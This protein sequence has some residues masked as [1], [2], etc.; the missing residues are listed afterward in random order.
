MFAYYK[1]E[2]LGNCCLY[3]CFLY[4][5]KTLVTFMTAYLFICICCFESD[6]VAN[7]RSHQ[8]IK[9]LNGLCSVTVLYV[10]LLPFNGLY[11]RTT[12]VSRYQKGKTNVDF[13]GARD[14][15]WQWHQLGHMHVCTSLQTDNHASTPPLCFLQAGCCMLIVC[16]FTWRKVRMCNDNNIWIFMTWYYILWVYK[17]ACRIFNSYYDNI[18]ML[19]VYH[20]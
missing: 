10:T 16:Y 1:T 20:L 15:E 13:N 18:L 3:F 11:S 9:K 19:S 12:W 5:S 14:S 8:C 6:C 17:N 4:L 2:Y 7:I